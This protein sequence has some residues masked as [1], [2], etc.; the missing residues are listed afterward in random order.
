MYQVGASSHFVNQ[1]SIERQFLHV[2]S[3][4]PLHAHLVQN[5]KVSVGRESILDRFSDR[6]HALAYAI[7]EYSSWNTYITNNSKNERVTSF[8]G[9]SHMQRIVSDAPALLCVHCV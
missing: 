5:L 3:F 2:Q 9:I 4:F 1:S 6:S 7:L 8:I